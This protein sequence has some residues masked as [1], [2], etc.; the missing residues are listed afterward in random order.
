MVD[1]V[2]VRRNPESAGGPCAIETLACTS[3]EELL[4]ELLSS[5]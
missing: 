4:G 2:N 5:V 1:D 3:G